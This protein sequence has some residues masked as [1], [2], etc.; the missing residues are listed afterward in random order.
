MKQD[1]LNKGSSLQLPSEAFFLNIVH[2]P[3]GGCF[4][5]HFCLLTL[6]YSLQ[7]ARSNSWH[8]RY[9][10]LTYLQTMVFYNLFIFLNN[11][12]AVNDIRWL[13]IKL[14]EDE[15]LEASDPFSALLSHHCFLPLSSFM[16]KLTCKLIQD[17]FLAQHS[18]Y[19]ENE[20]YRI[21]FF[22][23]HCRKTVDNKI[24]H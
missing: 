13:V 22:H 2:F 5:W 20:L 12:E 15:Q 18:S 10:I 3:S 17:L 1:Y 14:L 6:I 24:F 19:F 11:S 23:I 16:E 4:L 8:A 9:T 21:C 7:T